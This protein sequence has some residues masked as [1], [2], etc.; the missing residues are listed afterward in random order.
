MIDALR[1][2]CEIV[3][4]WMPQSLSDIV[5]IDS[6]NVLVPSGN[7]PLTEPVLTQVYIARWFQ[8]VTVS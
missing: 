5:N 3:L 7:K 8:W 2:S 6:G 1:A 4:S